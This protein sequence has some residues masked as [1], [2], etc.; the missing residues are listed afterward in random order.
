MGEV[1]VG[2]G[3]G[4]VRRKGICQAASDKADILV[5]INREA[6]ARSRGS[7]VHGLRERI[8]KVK[9]NSMAELLP[10]ACLQGVVR[11]AAN[12]TPSIHGESLV[13]QEFA[14]ASVESRR[15]VKEIAARADVVGGLE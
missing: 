3:A 13:I 11:R 7:N 4:Q 5:A 10:Q 1:I 14:R 8:V 12:G 6:H 15:T 9:L 2:D